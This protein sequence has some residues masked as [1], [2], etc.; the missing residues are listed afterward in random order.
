VNGTVFAASLDQVLNP[1]QRPGN[2]AVPDN[3]AVHKVGG[4]AEVVKNH[5]A[6]LLY[7]PPYSPDFNP[8]KLAFSKRKTG[9]RTAEARTRDVLVKAI[10]MA[11]EWIS[12]QDAKKLT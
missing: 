8:I 5:G 2:V 10:R 6:Q 7:L 9:L 11:A 4:L 12:A 3:L 1:T